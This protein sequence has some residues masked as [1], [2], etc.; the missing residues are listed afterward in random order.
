MMLA[1]GDVVRVRGDKELGTV[2]GLAPGAVLLRTSG[3]TVRTA[4][5]TDIEM[6]ARGSMPKTQTTE[7]TY[8][9]FIAV[10][11]IVGMLTGVTVGQLGAGLVLSAALTLSSS[12]SVVSLLTSLFL[13]PRRIRV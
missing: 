1:L 11:V 3:D 4:H 8:L 9:V 10:G 13:R 6:V 2:A 7:V 5:P 12:A